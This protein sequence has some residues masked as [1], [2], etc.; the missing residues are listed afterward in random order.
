MNNNENVVKIG[1]DKESMDN[2]VSTATPI[3]KTGLKYYAIYTIISLVI[4]VLLAIAI[5][6][7]YGYLVNKQEETYQ[8]NLKEMQDRQEEISRQNLENYN[9]SRDENEENFKEF[10]QEVTDAY[11]EESTSLEDKAKAEFE[12]NKAEL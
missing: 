11:K 6:V 1:V 7:G 10:Q 2:L 9:E 12:K 4:F 8:K 5:F 3:V